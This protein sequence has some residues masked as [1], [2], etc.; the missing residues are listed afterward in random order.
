MSCSQLHGPNLHAQPADTVFARSDTAA[1]I[2]FIAQFCAVSVRKRRLL[3]SVSGADAREAIQTET[4]V[5]GDTDEVEEA[6]VI[7]Q[8]TKMN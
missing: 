5:L 6:S 4:A 8:K 3:I 2:N 1:T 7:F